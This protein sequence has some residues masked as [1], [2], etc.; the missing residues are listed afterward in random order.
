MNYIKI[1]LK[2]AE[3]QN[4]VLNLL[5]NRSSVIVKLCINLECNSVQSLY[6]SNGRKMFI[7]LRI[8]VSYKHLQ[9]NWKK[10]Y[11]S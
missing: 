9:L 2:W 3:D 7:L 6:Y 10:T 5:M 4:Q 8:Q 1:I 11:K